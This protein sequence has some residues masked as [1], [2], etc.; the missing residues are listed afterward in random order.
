MDI[1]INAYFV[2]NLKIILIFSLYHGK[3]LKFNQSEG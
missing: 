1:E 2:A 3:F